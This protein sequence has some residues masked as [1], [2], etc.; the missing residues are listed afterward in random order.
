[1]HERTSSGVDGH[2]TDSVAELRV[3]GSVLK[4]PALSRQRSVQRFRFRGVLGTITLR[5]NRPMVQYVDAGTISDHAVHLDD[6]VRP[7]SRDTRVRAHFSFVHLSPS[8]L[9]DQPWDNYGA[10]NDGEVR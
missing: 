6:P 4:S 10:A 7:R 1:M 2:L 8:A 9:C 5:H 3:A